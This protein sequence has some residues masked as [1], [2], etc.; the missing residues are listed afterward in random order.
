[1]SKNMSNLYQDPNSSTRDGT[2]VSSSVRLLLLD[3]GVCR[4]WS[5]YMMNTKTMRTIKIANVTIIWTEINT[6]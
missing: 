2:I 6:K 4:F 5:S 3:C 1:M